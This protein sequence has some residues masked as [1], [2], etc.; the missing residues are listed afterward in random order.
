V[1]QL[2]LIGYELLAGARPYADPE[3]L[4][5]R[6]GEEVA[7]PESAAWA[8]V[9]PPLRAVIARALRRDP[10]ARYPDAGA[11]A[12]AL[13]A[14]DG[15]A[16]PADDDDATLFL[17]TPVAAPVLDVLPAPP[18]PSPTAPVPVE[19]V[20]AEPLSHPSPGPPARRFKPAVLGL[21]VVLL[22]LALAVWATRRNPSPAPGAVAADTGAVAELHDKFLR[23]QGEVAGGASDAPADGDTPAAEDTTAS[24]QETEAA[25]RQTAAAVQAA[26]I[27]MHGAWSAGDMDRV[28]SHYADRVDYYGVEGAS[29][30]F[31]RRNVA[32]TVERYDRRV[33]TINGQATMFVEP[34]LARVLV[35]K[36]WD[37]EGR[38]ERWTG[39]MRQELM[40]RLRGGE[41]LIVAEKTNEVFNENRSRP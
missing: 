36:D 35:T 39:S 7:P 24:V 10:A 11:F 17:V 25:Q 27:D 4:R 32:K 20:S 2:G 26:V 8:A 30:S 37:F 23:L 15:G 28:M 34:D 3:R 14:A 22:L 40:L 38:R 18:V 5:I 6:G 29:K 16:L 41:W 21:P 13:A 33:I 12:D 19:P 1:Y 31:V 9:E